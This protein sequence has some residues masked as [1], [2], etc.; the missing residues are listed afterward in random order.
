MTDNPSY[1]SGDMYGQDAIEYAHEELGEM[2]STDREVSDLPKTVREYEEKLTTSVHPS[3]VREFENG[4]LIDGRHDKS[5]V[6]PK[7]MIGQ[8]PRFWVTENSMFWIYFKK[9]GDYYLF[10]LSTI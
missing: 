7:E 6:N 3:F 10:K 4:Y 8:K 2:V 5:V 9:E 1:Q